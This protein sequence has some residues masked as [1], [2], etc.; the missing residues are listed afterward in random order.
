[1]REESGVLRGGAFSLHIVCHVGKFQSILEVV[2]SLSLLTVQATKLTPS[3]SHHIGSTLQKTHIHKLTFILTHML[4]HTHIGVH[5]HLGTHT[6]THLPDKM[7][8]LLAR[9]RLTPS[10]LQSQDHTEKVSPRSS[11]ADIVCV[12]VCVCN[13]S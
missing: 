13:N 3:P 7:L 12:C 6:H 5:T 4:T 9:T 1:M 8:F 11:M 10:S 2:L